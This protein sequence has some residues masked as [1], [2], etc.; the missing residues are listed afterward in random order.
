M[1]YGWTGGWA[2][3]V[4]MILFWVAILAV[5][6]LIVRSLGSSEARAGRARDAMEILD[7]RFARGEIS[8]DE[9]TSRRRVLE[10]TR[11]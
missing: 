2:G 7:E 10:V 6:Y 4:W 5:V 3:M 1:M 9:Y 11:R 8:E